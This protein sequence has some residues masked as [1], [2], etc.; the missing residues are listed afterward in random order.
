MLELNLKEWHEKWAAI[1]QE[2]DRLEASE[3]LTV[4]QRVEDFLLLCATA[5]Y[6]LTETETM[7]CSERTEELLALESRL[8]RLDEWRAK[9]N[10]TA[11]NSI[12]TR[13]R[14]SAAA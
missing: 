13:S 5:A 4:A 10:G 11:R 6:Q 7:F 3:N 9:S 12:S 2:E 8:R 1:E 14:N